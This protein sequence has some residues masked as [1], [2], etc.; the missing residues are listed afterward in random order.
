MADTRGGSELPDLPEAVPAPRRRWAPQLI[1]I[2]P[3]VA[4]LAGGWL[5]VKAILERGPTITISF[6]TGDGLEA[7]KTKIKYKDVDIGRVKEIALAEDR[8]RVVATAELDKDAADFLVEDTRFWAVRPRITAG[9]VSGLGTLLSGPYITVDPGR[10]RE[11]RRAFVALD[12][13][14]VVTF[15]DPGREF[16][17]R[18]DTLGSHDVGV[19][20]YFRRLPVGEVVARELDRDGKGVSIRVFVRAP[21]DQYVTAN[22]RFWN[23]SGIDVSLDAAGV[24]VQTESLVSIL[25]GG[26]AFQTPPEAGV[27]PAADANAVFN[28]FQTREAAMKQPDLQVEHFVLVFKQSVRGLSVG[29][30]VDFRGVTIG[31]VVKI[32]VEFDPKTFN[33]VQPVEIHLFPDRLRARSSD[34]GASLPVPQTAEARLRRAQ[35]F[36]EK[37]FRAQI[38]TGNL[39]TGQSYVAVDFFPDAP[40]VKLDV[41][42][43]PLEFPTIP[44]QFEELEA[45]VASILK[46]LDRVQYEQISGDVRKVLATLDQTLKSADVLVKRLDT[47]T[48]PELN[49]ALE[50]GRRALKSADTALAAE[51]PLQTDLRET[52]RELTRAAASIRVLADYLDRQ[53]QSLLF[54]KPAEEP[55]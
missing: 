37:G 45:T 53:P 17:L 8:K 11:K 6:Q 52:L 15:E 21:F 41:T 32:G 47:E 3:I 33:F 36:A 48:T 40:K 30:P 26:I 46:K 10:A 35:I 54:G 28:L 24:R 44:G 12:V 7:G 25:I 5:A 18:A 39:L 50:E 42:R 19:P 49:R 43:R 22:T 9:G 31:E 14:P 51:S 13:P 27:A 20:V 1:W 55:K 38:R 34:S 4:V 2:I 16:V 29:A 23:A